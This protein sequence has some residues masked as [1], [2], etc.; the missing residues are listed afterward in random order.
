MGNNIKEEMNSKQTINISKLLILVLALQGAMSYNWDSNTTD[1]KTVVHTSGYST[2]VSTSTT[3]VGKIG[4]AIS[5]AFSKAKKNTA[6]GDANCHGQGI[7]SANSCNPKKHNCHCF[8]SCKQ[9]CPE[10]QRTYK[11]MFNSF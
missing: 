6:G 4:A 5:S 9:G 10:I 1:S 7:L 2:S 11:H 3:I 8:K